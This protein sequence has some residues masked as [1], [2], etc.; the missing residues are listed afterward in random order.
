MSFIGTDYTPDDE[1]LRT[2]GLTREQYDAYVKA[3]TATSGSSPTT[4]VK[5]MSSTEVT[6][7]IRGFAELKDYD[8]LFVFLDDLVNTGR[9]T[10]DQADEI[11]DMYGP[12]V[13]NPTLDW[14][15]NF[16]IH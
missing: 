2:A 12:V 11:A 13:L 8:G 14:K 6:E 16:G 5:A 7:A 1:L 10:E 15:K 3:A 9:M 4:N